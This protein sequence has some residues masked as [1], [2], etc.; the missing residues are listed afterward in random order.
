MSPT[1][2]LQAISA[3]A[4]VTLCH[5][6]WYD[7]A[8]HLLRLRIG[9]GETD[10]AILEASRLAEIAVRVLALDAEDFIE[11]AATVPERSWANDLA[12]CAFPAEPRDPRRAALGSLVPLYELMLEVIDLRGERQEPQALVVTAHLIGEY[13]CQLGWESALG[14]AGDPLRMGEYVG[15][16]WGTS[17]HACPHNSAMRQT[18]KRSLNACGGDVPGYT[19]YL[20]KFHSRLGDT[21]AVCAMN[22]ETIDAGERP[23]VGPT[24]P[25]PCTWAVR[26]TREARRDLDARMRLALVYLDSP[27]VALR[28]HAPVGHFFGVPSTSEIAQGWLRTWQKLTVQWPDGSNPLLAQAAADPSEVLPGLSALVTTV[29]GRP[30]RS[31]TLLSRIGDDII[32]SLQR[33]SE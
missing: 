29:A 1:S 17:D 25:N 28:H 2:T 7:A 9:A 6:H 22:H 31:G 10:P 32:A 19:S 12:A 23:D 11:L 13:L 14:H 33:A 21:L 18:A 24:C 30:V 8:A 4:L 5:S 15:E 27:L 16:R 20:N 26:G 3:R